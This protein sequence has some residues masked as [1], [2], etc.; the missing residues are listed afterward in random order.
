MITQPGIYHLRTEFTNF[1]FVTYLEP[2]EYDGS[3][4]YWYLGLEGNPDFTEYYGVFTIGSSMMT[5]STLITPLPAST[6][7]QNYPELLI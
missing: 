5:R 4:A 6:L 7:K 1:T 3:K 2:G